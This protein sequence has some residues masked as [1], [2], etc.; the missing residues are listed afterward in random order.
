MDLDWARNNQ[1]LLSRG[2]TNDAGAAQANTA[3]GQAPPRGQNRYPKFTLWPVLYGSS[4]FLRDQ[5]FNG[6]C[7]T[8][9]LGNPLLFITFTCNPIHYP[10]WDEIVSL[11]LPGQTAMDNAELTAEAT[12]HHDN[13]P[14]TPAENEH[15]ESGSDHGDSAGNGNPNSN[16]EPSDPTSIN[17]TP[18]SAA[19]TT[20][21]TDVV[22]LIAGH[23]EG[24]PPG[25]QRC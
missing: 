24:N 7:L 23:S 22:D 3:N 17:T 5:T 6:L 10:N 13:D 25:R 15:D 9:N 8:R 14:D 4:N 16:A 1:A 2:R 12:E 20:T 18:T 11:L 19:P 21:T